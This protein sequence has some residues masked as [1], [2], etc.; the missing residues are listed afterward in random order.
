[1]AVALEPARAHGGLSSNARTTSVGACN[2]AMVRAPTCTTWRSGVELR[3]RDTGRI[4][5]A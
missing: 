3:H 5:G 2:L 4:A 1:M